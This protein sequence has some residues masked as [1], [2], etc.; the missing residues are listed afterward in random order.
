[1]NR[2][3][4]VLLFILLTPIGT[5]AA[6]KE[7]NFAVKG[8]AAAPC[9][10]FTEERQKLSPAYG[11]AMA[12]VTG[13]ISAYNQLKPDTYD[14]IPWQS[15]EMLSSIIAEHCKNNPGE[16]LFHATM[17]L[18][19]GIEQDR[20]RISSDIIA[21]QVGDKRINIY[22]D[23]VFRIQSALKDKGHLKVKWG[24]GDY[25]NSTMSAMKAFQAE[26][27]LEPTGLPDQ[28]TMFLLFSRQ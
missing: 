8:L 16:L 17:R 23:M 21:I 20:L 19:N 12:W 9:A 5:L 24:S 14:I 6:D 11:E 3:L 2:P 4:L 15:A 22:K 13:Y 27:N 28:Q 25:D 26:N 10:S 18:I 7:N 1:M